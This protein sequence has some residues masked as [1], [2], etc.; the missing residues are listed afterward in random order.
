MAGSILELKRFE[1]YNNSLSS[2]KI[3]LVW[4]RVPC[5]APNFLQSAELKPPTPLYARLAQ[6]VEQSYNG[7]DVKSK[8]LL[9]RTKKSVLIP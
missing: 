4:V 5:R 6:L 3:D 8:N 2:V 9:L 7:N 1:N